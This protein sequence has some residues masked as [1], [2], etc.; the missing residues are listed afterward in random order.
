[1]AGKL[2]AHE[3]RDS[4]ST[5]LLDASECYE[6]ITLCRRRVVFL[7]P[8]IFVIADRVE[9]NCTTLSWL[10]QGYNND[11]QARWMCADDR[12]VLFRPSVRLH[13]FFAAPIQ[14]YAIAQGSLGNEPRDILRLQATLTGSTLTTV[15]IPSRLAEAEPECTREHDGT[16]TIHFRGQAHRITPV[17]G[18]E[19]T[20]DGIR[21]TV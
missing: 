14:H 1:M 20:V 12:A 17:H 5:A 16:M 9:G 21:Y 3:H 11:G 7:R 4:R 18:D 15:L 19:L 8:D 2:L 10:T 13:I 6:D